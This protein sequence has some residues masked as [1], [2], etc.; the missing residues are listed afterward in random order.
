M[1]GEDN[2]I[3]TQKTTRIENPRGKKAGWESRGSNHVENV[4]N[5]SSGRTTLRK[6]D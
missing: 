1:S 4:L 2:G 5:K 3:H 6:L